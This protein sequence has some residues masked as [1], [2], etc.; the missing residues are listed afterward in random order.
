MSTRSVIA[1]PTE[2]G[3]WIGR[4]VHFDG[5][6][7]AMVP[8]YLRLVNEKGVDR[9][10]DILINFNAGWS[11]ITSNPT[12]GEYYSD[13]RFKTVSNYGVAYTTKKMTFMG[14]ADYQQASMDDWISNTDEDHWCEWAYVLHPDHLEVFESTAEGWKHHSNVAYNA[15]DYLDSAG[16]PQPLP[17][18]ILV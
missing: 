8:E 10:I 16:S 11:Q 5:Y 14:Q 13:G 12:L 4:Y 2:D 3:G 6:P 1:K 17:T 9:C 7:E 15:D 18:S